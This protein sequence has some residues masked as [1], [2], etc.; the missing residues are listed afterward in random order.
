MVR[1]IFFCVLWAGLIGLAQS[2]VGA[3]D[4]ATEPS[5]AP[6]PARMVGQ[7][8]NL[9]AH[10]TD[11]SF[12]VGQILPGTT[13]SGG[14]EQTRLCI[15]SAG[16]SDWQ[17][18]TDLPARAVCLS[19]RGP[20]LAVLLE[21]GD[22]LLISNDGSGTTGQPLPGN[23]RILTFAGDGSTLWAVGTPPQQASAADASAQPATRPVKASANT[24]QTVLYVMQG[25][26]W[27][28]ADGPHLPAD[29]H[30][31]AAISLAIVDRTPW[32]A[33]RR[34]DATIE[35]RHQTPAGWVQAGRT[36]SGRN[37]SDRALA[38]RFPAPPAAGAFK[39]LQGLT[40]AT[41]WR[42]SAG[43]DQLDQFQA[44]DSSKQISLN[45]VDSPVTDRTATYANQ[46]IRQIALVGGKMIEQ[47]YSPL[48]LAPEGKSTQIVLPAPATPSI[49][50]GLFNIALLVALG[51]AV[52]SSIGRRKASK[53]AEANAE[54]N[55]EAQTQKLVM[56]DLS[57]RF[58]AG[59][60][61]GFPFVV[62]AILFL[63][64]A[65]AAHFHG[66]LMADQSIWNAA[67]I[68]GAVA[69]FVYLSH[70]LLSETFAGRSLGKMLLGLRV[71]S[72]DGSTPDRASLLIRNLLRILDIGLMGV[73]LTL[74]L[75]SPLRQRIGDVA[76]NTVVIRDRVKPEGNLIE[77]PKEKTPAAMDVQPPAASG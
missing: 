66:D 46:L 11:D 68:S 43:A 62:P 77:P 24:A 15:R 65:R 5:I 36:P 17:H 52:F 48:T 32:I 37:G 39:L 9:L 73:P 30:S 25:D 67:L 13:A 14:E 2:P 57:R 44:D 20:Q 16:G 1:A 50:S 51:F 70:T 35:V 31:D 21:G 75:F 29:I 18:L 55:A 3:A 54:P 7:E 56:A 27:K 34:P 64:C 4:P 33:F 69:M 26:A 71:V 6:G 22:W 12:W 47:D 63:E 49:F 59:V 74:I 72:L 53:E 41:L 61:D 19:N 10:G 23:A 40:P 38:G 60:I 28:I 8:Q 45:A 42:A 76:A 58:A